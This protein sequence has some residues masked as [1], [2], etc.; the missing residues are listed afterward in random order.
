MAE[1]ASAD[2]FQIEKVDEDSSDDS[3]D[4]DS[5]SVAE[6]PPSSSDSQEKET[7]KWIEIDLDAFKEQNSCVDDRDVSVQSVEALPT[8]FDSEKPAPK[9]VLIE[10]L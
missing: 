6:E 1:T 10:E 8:A 3:S 9:R 7:T 5:D 4:S 2:A